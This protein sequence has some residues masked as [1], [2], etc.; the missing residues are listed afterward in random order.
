M[1]Q[2]DLQR[3]HQ[4]ELGREVILEGLL[5]RDGSLLAGRHRLQHLAGVG[6]PEQLDQ[7]LCEDPAV[8]VVPVADLVSQADVVE[9]QGPPISLE[10]WKV[11][12]RRDPV[13]RVCSHVVESPWAR[14]PGDRA[15]ELVDDALLGRSNERPPRVE[16]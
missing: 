14:A 13:A 8:G 6:H 9:G 7:I 12:H 3:L 4:S 16:A 2:F 10:D 1:V 5:N 15:L 11:I